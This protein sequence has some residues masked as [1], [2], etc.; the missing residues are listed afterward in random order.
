LLD[1]LSE[2]MKAGRQTLKQSGFADRS[3]IAATV[4]DLVLSDLL[5][6]SKVQNVW[7]A[8]GIQTVVTD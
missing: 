2:M 5:Q 1:F 4:S 7:L 8:T 6:R 3:Q